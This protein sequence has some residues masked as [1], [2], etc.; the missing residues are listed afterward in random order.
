MHIKE[1]IDATYETITKNGDAQRTLT[2][3]N[4][5]LQ[6][7]GLLKLYPSILR[8]LM[9]KLRRKTKSS[10]PVVIVARERDVERQQTEIQHALAQLGSTDYEVRTDETMIGGYIV[11]NRDIRIDKSYKHALLHAYHRLTD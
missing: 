5:Y 8:G 6:K 3:L 4:L 9:E 1:Y 11:K 10:V 7:R 2:S